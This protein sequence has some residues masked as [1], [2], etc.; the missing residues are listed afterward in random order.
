[1]PTTTTPRALTYRQRLALSVNAFPRSVT[2]YPIPGS[3][4][5]AHTKRLDPATSRRSW[6]TAL[7]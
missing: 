5:L 7:V 4:R 3:R 1:M 6:S 2:H